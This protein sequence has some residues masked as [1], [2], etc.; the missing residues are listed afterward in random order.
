[1]RK[2]IIV[3]LL[4]IFSLCLVVVSILIIYSI[5]HQDSVENGIVDYIN[6]SF[7]NSVHIE[8]FHL[9]YLNNFPNARLKLSNVVL[10]DDTTELINIGSIQILFN[11]RQFLQ[12]SIKINRIIVSDAMVINKIDSNG[13]KPVFKIAHHEPGKK[14]TSIPVDIYS[15]DLELNNVK[16]YLT[17]DYK[18]NET[19]A[20]IQQS[21]FN[22][23][24]NKDLIKLSGNFEG[25]LDSLKSGGITL[26]SNKKVIGKDI[27]LK[28]N[29]E[30]QHTYLESGYLKSNTLTLHP[31]IS[32][33]K[34]ENGNK[35]K[36][37]IESQGNL[38]DHLSILNL[39]DNIRLNQI[40]EDA[41]IKISYN[42]D[43]LVNPT[44]RPFNQLIFEIKNADFDS[45][46]L[47][48]PVRDLH[49]IAN[50]NNGELHGPA[51]NNLIVDILNF[52]VE[53]SY[54]D[55]QLTINNFKDPIVK[56]HF[57][58]EIDLYH[59]L[60]ED[61]ITASGKINVDL[62]FDGKISEFK[63]LHLN[64]KQHAYGKIQID[65]VDLI[66]NKSQQRISIPT[67]KL[68]LD[69]HFIRIEDLKGQIMD[70]NIE[71]QAELNNLDQFILGHN[72]PLTGNID[73]SSDYFDLSS[74]NLT[75]DTLKKDE[76]YFRMPNLNVDLNIR[77]NKIDTDFGS[78]DHLIISGNLDHDTFN[79]Y[80]MIF[81]FME[82][83]I[84]SNLSI[85]I[86]ADDG[87]QITGGRINAQFNQLD[88]DDLLDIPRK[89]NGS[90]KTTNL[91]QNI[92]MKME[93]SIKNGIVFE[94]EFSDL[95]MTVNFSKGDIEVEKFTTGFLNGNLS[96]NSE[97]KYNADGIWL[98][99]AEGNAIFPYLSVREL[100]N[101]FH[102]KELSSDKPKKITT[103]PELVDINIDIE[104]DSLL[105]GTNMFNDIHTGLKVS[106]DEIDLEDFS[107]KL[108]KG[109]GQ[110]DLQ[111]IDYL[112]QEPRVNGNIDIAIDSTNVQTI[113]ET[114]SG[115]STNE[116]HKEEQIAHTIPYNI[117]L[118]VNLT[119]RY[120]QFQSL[121]VE[122]LNLS[123]SLTD[124]TLSIS[125]INF[126]TSEGYVEFSGLC[127]QNIN[128]TIDGHF[129]STGT[130]LSIEP[131]IS[132]FSKADLSNE[133]YGNFEGYI[134]YNAEGLFQMDSLLNLVNEQ[135]LFYADIVIE[136]G[137]IFN[138][139]ELDTTFSF[140]GHK[141]KD[142]ILIKNS[143]FQMYIDGTNMIIQDILV[144]NSISDMNIFGKY[145]LYDS[146]VNLNFR[147]S[148]MDLFFRTKKK[149]YID[150]EQGKIRLF[151]DLSIFIE[152][153]NSSP[154]HR[155][156]IHPKRK[157]R[158]KRREL[159]NEID[160]I[161]NKYRTRLN[162]IYLEAE[163]MLQESKLP[164]EV[165]NKQ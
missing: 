31:T 73:I 111:V 134:S 113:Y 26:F 130:N 125:D 68:S 33:R 6:S 45:P 72:T 12:D 10:F 124:G 139:P 141:S 85:L 147:V 86:N 96:I 9:T 64:N 60:H 42:Q 162:E 99:Q 156:K 79:I 153:D 5:K 47:P 89:N 135:N 106:R 29:T 23:D 146:V 149:R 163:P 94:S 74:L 58:S 108:N 14:R 61:I 67:A 66:L 17:N 54:V 158:L 19:Y 41:E 116:K 100:L 123:S 13:N 82:G 104:I 75:N 32:F 78:I 22:L 133:A 52:K 87:P 92:N 50:Y 59:F 27:V 1:M 20:T 77:A 102:N 112:K 25:E 37:K 157:H 34:K 161:T 159:A 145:Y 98:I 97:I 121:V 18:K 4:S 76:K 3:S 140:I 48:Y 148:L 11:L 43:G 119:A 35:V 51:T 155:I 62:F 36:L 46:I 24:I 144:N 44:T 90:T 80:N 8:G 154:K 93:L 56:G 21:L 16:L 109:L 15:P 132:S 83:N 107:I 88:I 2:I 143:E 152:L 103:I 55:A 120:L 65:S 164:L 28:I 81:D 69:N 131:L 151:K 105:Y 127:Y 38:D 126:N 63:E 53:E 84:E 137:K 70:S 117:D 110:I 138:N 160:N 57:K 49:V 95:D 91:P 30:E 40:N 165:K 150:T 101:D 118:D 142:S 114:I 71:I 115:F 122:N 136:E 39:P 7:N 128:K 129:Y